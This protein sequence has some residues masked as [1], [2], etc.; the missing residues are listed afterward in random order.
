MT[1]FDPTWL[2]LR[3]AADAAARSPELLAKIAEHFVGLEKATIVDLGCGTGS[4]LRALSPILP[5]R[6]RWLM[7]DGDATV[8]DAAPSR[9]AAWADSSGSLD[10]GMRLEF[11]GKKIEVA[12]QRSDLAADPLPIGPGEADMIGASALF[13]LVSADW[14][15]RFADALTSRSAAFYAALTYDGRMT[16]TPPHPADARAESLFNRHQTT[17]KG[18]G[19]A[20][21]PNGAAE[22]MRALSARGFQTMSAAS[23]WLLDASDATLIQ[24]TV[25]GVAAAMT[26][27]EAAD[28]IEEWRRSPRSRAVIGHQD[29]FASR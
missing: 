3:E 17:D 19:A 23:P 4:L 7:I 20:L 10:G 24:A 22:L 2:D 1:G 8:L 18:T 14:L 6:Q 26:E 5:A 11:A 9:L 15:D 27:M 12:F 16:W 28:W 25:D 13:D 21:G 29:V